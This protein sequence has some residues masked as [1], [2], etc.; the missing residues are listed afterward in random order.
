MKTYS[1]RAVE[2]LSSLGI[3][4]GARPDLSKTPEAL[5]CELLNNKEF[6]GGSNYGFL[7]LV[8][9]KNHD[10]ISVANLEKEFENIEEVG[11]ATLSAICRF[12]YNQTKDP[13]FKNFKFYRLKRPYYN[14]EI[15]RDRI[16]SGA[17]DLDLDEFHI[18]SRPYGV[19][20]EKKI[21]SRREL[22]ESSIWFK[23]RLRM[24]TNVRAD[25]FS[26]LSRNDR[27]PTYYALSRELEISLSSARK[28]FSEYHEYG[29]LIV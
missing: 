23:N 9:L 24:G 19:Q 15:S 3:N 10:L 7:K 28:Y 4:Y 12:T 5:I 1:Q 13:R 17:V 14:G 11:K 6:I 8:F 21:L 25:V 16:D 29:D 18:C 26:I 27:I 22:I 20:S 2:I